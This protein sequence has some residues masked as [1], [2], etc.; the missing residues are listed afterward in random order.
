MKLPNFD[1]VNSKK[2]APKF[3]FFNKKNSNDP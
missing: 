2:C 3:E 1:Y